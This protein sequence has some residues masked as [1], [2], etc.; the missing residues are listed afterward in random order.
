MPRSASLDANHTHTFMKTTFTLDNPKIKLARQ[1]E[2]T[3]STINK[4]IKR[5]RRK[6]LP[7]G[8]DFCDFACKFGDTEEDAAPCHLKDV[9]KLIDA[10]EAKGQ[11]T[12]YLEIVAVGGVRQ[13][14]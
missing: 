13:K 5:E 9:F 10:A 4:Y 12:F 6:E 2:A 7:D 3:K 1:V 11:T 8:V 14:S